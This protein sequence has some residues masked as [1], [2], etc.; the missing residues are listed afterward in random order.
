MYNLALALPH[1]THHPNRFGI[2]TTN[3]SQPTP[4]KFYL[5]PRIHQPPDASFQGSVPQQGIF[6]KNWKI[7]KPKKLKFKKLYGV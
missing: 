5:S 4:D 6:Q 3:P 2:F 1:T 7:E